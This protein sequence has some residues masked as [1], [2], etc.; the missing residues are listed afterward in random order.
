VVKRLLKRQ[1]ESTTVSWAV[2]NPT[3]NWLHGA[4]LQ[5]D[6]SPNLPPTLAYPKRWLSSF[7][8]PF[9]TVTITAHASE[10][11]LDVAMGLVTYTVTLQEIVSIS[12]GGRTLNTEHLA[13]PYSF[14]VQVIESIPPQPSPLVLVTEQPSVKY[15]KDRM[16][17]VSW[18]VTNPTANPIQAYLHLVNV[19]ASDGRIILGPLV[20]IPAMS[21]RNVGTIHD[22]QHLA[23]GDYK[24]S[25][26]VIDPTLAEDRIVGGVYVDWVMTLT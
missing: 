4:V 2:R 12:D 24:M 26:A 9:A 20:W 13:G 25:S 17:A 11:L 14:E 22:T 6:R 23:A 8:P 5:L 21:T 10:P 18:D 19:T 16:V 3:G 7:I 15:L 1:G